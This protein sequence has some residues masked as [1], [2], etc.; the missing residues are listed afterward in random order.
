M[1]MW[2]L[3]NVTWFLLYF[4]H[5]RIVKRTN[6]FTIVNENFSQVALS[7]LCLC[8]FNK[9]WPQKTGLFSPKLNHLKMRYNYLVNHGHHLKEEVLCAYLLCE[10]TFIFCDMQKTSDSIFKNTSD[11]MQ[12]DHR[13][14]FPTRTVDCNMH[15]NQ[16]L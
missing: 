9:E 2:D 3:L 12:S 4:M 15:I 6:N 8:Q 1:Q 11:L 5:I 10:E 16:L 13:V 7:Q 14:Q